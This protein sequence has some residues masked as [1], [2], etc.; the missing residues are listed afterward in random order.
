MEWRAVSRDKALDMLSTALNCRFDDE[1]LRISAVSECLRSVLYQYSISETEEARQ[2]VTSLRLTSA[3][4]RKLV[5]LWPDIADIDNAIHPGIMSILNS[6]AEL[7]DMI[8]LEGGNW[9]TAPPHA[10]RIDNKMAVFFGGEPS[11]TFST[12][13]VLRDPLII[14]PKRNHV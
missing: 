6:L 3:V 14:S 10:V 5:P 12:G 9:L 4:R 13:V 7:G 11:C 8:K 1:G 2:T